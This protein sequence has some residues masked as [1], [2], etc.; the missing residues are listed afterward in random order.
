MDCDNITRSSNN[1]EKKEIFL[2]NKKIK[3]NT[4]YNIW[5]TFPQI[6][7]FGMS[8][9]GF[10]SIFQSIDEAFDDVYVQRVFTDSKTTSKNIN[11]VDLIAFSV[12]FEL[13]HF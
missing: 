13:V 10:V 1:K 5:L 4:N 8:S 6:Y 3:N 12:S 2:Y 9:L 11:E 7:S